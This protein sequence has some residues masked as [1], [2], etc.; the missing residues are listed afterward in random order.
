MSEQVYEL[1]PSTQVMSAA[2]E[3]DKQS[4]ISDERH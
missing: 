2:Q 1:T 4:S 3:F